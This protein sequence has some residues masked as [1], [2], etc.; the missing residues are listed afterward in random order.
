MRETPRETQTTISVVV[1]VFGSSALLS[2]LHRRLREELLQISESFEIIF[3][4][5]CGPGNSLEVLRG[6]AGNDPSVVVVEMISNV[7]Q[8]GATVHGIAE[9]R[10][11]FVVTIDDDLQ[12]WPEDIRFL[13]QELITKNMDL[14]VGRFPVRKHSLFRKIGSEL[15]RRL[16]VRSLPVPRSTHFS[17]FRI[18]RRSVFENYFGDGALTNPTPGW[19][20][21]T[22][23]RHHEIEVRH[24]ER[25]QGNSTYS[26]ASLIKNAR[27]LMSGLFDVGLQIAV[28]V[29]ILQI[30]VAVVAG[31]YMFFQYWNGNINSPGYT[32]I[33]L[34]LLTVIGLLGAGI[35]MLAQYLRSLKTLIV[36]K[37]ASS[38][39][40]VLRSELKN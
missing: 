15:T 21:F 16:A 27:P 36:N 7:G 18:M 22:A 39:R 25:S 33:I 1:P 4:N 12:Q 5:D 29:S 20:Y 23:S 40:S 10:G 37:P 8:L 19:M 32:S 2:E 6:I 34:L 28:G 17:S 35:A 26:L 31:G 13:Y 14:V 24:A 3:V 11:Q 9:S 30:I 38:V